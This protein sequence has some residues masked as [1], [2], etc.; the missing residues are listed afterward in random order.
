MKPS[1][2]PKR[3]LSRLKLK[4]NPSQLMELSET[5]PSHKRQI[6]KREI[7]DLISTFDTEY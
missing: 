6:A 5:S 1:V 7:S 3:V 2:S 4:G